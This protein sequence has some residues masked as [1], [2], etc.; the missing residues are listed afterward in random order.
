VG[1]ENKK[2]RFGII[3]TG[4]IAK[5]HITSI[6]ELDNCELIALASS[7][8]VR[9]AAAAAEFGVPAYAD[10]NTM[11]GEV[12]IDAVIICTQSGNHAGPTIAAAKAG[13]H[14][15]VEKPLEVT[16]DR[17]QQMI[18][19]CHDANVQLACI[20]QNRFSPD[21]LKLKEAVTK[22]VLGNLI[23]GNA[24]IPWYRDPSYYAASSWK[25]TFAGDGGAAFMNQGVHTIDL[26]LDLMG[27]VESVFG[28]TK[29]ILH[30]IEGEDIGAGLLTFTNGA[31]GS[32]QAS[33]AM[34]PGYAE[35]LEIYGDKGSVILE[36]GKILHWNIQNEESSEQQI[37]AT[38]QP[39]GASDPLAINHNLHKA[40]IENFASSILNNKQPMI[41]GS[42]GLNAMQLILKLYES[43][44][45]ER[46][47]KLLL[48]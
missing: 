35:R 2:L 11:L 8:Q 37:P 5:H 45:E 28:K 30:N 22:G 47:V 41:A 31:M 48:S 9:A 44:K 13:K 21:Y 16:V 43:S 27:P 38:G 4:S 3:G 7:T 29:T 39:S 23:M 10:Y 40:Q 12:D 33:T 46:E 25:G 19:A 14:V 32:I 34:Y 26:L 18:T 20:F 6:R 36:A 17:A 15:L 42:E 1:L 24:Y